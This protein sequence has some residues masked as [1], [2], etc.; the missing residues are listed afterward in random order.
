[1]N[2][3]LIVED[4]AADAE[5]VKRALKKAGVK[6]PVKWIDDGARAMAYLESVAVPPTVVFLDVK[7]PGFT[8]FDILDRL[9]DNPNFN[10]TLRIVFSSLDDIGTIK[11][12][13]A[14][15]AQSFLSKPVSEEELADLIRA[16]QG[17]WLINYRL[18][19]GRKAATPPVK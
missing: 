11:E 1:M 4:S 8:G 12:A 17:H 14:H 16:F 19:Q 15:G 13:Y 7:L 18:R 9:R 6:N 3:I 5:E 2:E 10:R